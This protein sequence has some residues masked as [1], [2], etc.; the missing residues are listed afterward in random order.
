[1]TRRLD[2]TVLVAGVLV[3]ATSGG[4]WWNSNQAVAAP[5]VTTV[6][7]RPDP[8]AVPPPEPPASSE[9]TPGPGPVTPPPSA[10]PAVPVALSIPSLALGAEIDAVGVR[11]D[12]Q[13]AVPDDGDRV[14][15]YRFGPAPGADA[16]SAVL[17][18]HRDTRAEGP[19]VLFPVGELEV[20]NRIDVVRADWTTA[21]YRVVARESF[22]K[23]TLPSDQLFRR[24][25]APVLTVITCGGPYTPG[26][27][28]R[29]N[30]VITAVLDQVRT[31]GTTPSV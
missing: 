28:Y 29:D 21:R 9:A 4:L 3:A 15:W 8:A 13:V 14:G 18:G 19:G 1:M 26:E 7:A 25:G 11:D 27:G 31:P 20:G 30:V 22:S 23:D 6:G 17:V 12:G 10:D 5:E 16:G 24:E 2:A